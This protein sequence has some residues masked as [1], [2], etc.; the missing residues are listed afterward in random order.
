M[1]SLIKSTETPGTHLVRAIGD[2]PA[3]PAPQTQTDAAL[4][5]AR[6]RIE[7]LERAVADLAERREAAQA[8][9]ERAFERGREAGRAAGKSEAIAQDAER[10][11][12][13]E[14]ALRLARGDFGTALEGMERLSLLIARD[15]LDVLLGEA[16]YRSELL[17]HLIRSQ[18]TQTDQGS[19]VEIRV[20]QTDFPDAAAIE[21]LCAT[22]GGGGRVT[23][24]ADRSF[25][26]GE[27]N[28]T[29]ILGQADIGLRQQWG[30]MRRL[31]SDMAEEGQP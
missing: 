15:C 29:L 21:R 12:R 27:C 28:M 16:D 10:L 23:I 4:L 1:R 14:N 6:A 24:V 19:I 8:E 30:S 5:A 3:S 25:A 11:G 13:L 9:S 18:I 7:E 20:S 31:L 2:K 17:T 22:A 26:S